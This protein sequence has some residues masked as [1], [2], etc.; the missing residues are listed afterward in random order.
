MCIIV[1]SSSF[2]SCLPQ[3]A[4]AVHSFG[5]KTHIEK[6]ASPIFNVFSDLRHFLPT[7]KPQSQ[8]TSFFK[9]LRF[10][11]TIYFHY[12]GYY[13]LKKCCS[14]R[15]QTESQKKTP[16]LIF[17]RVKV[18]SWLDTFRRVQEIQ[19]LKLSCFGST[20]M[21]HFGSTHASP[22]LIALWRDST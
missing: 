1:G 2:W 10:L 18:S 17:Q 19:K 13:D 9:S 21:T 6:S 7:T 22:P 11:I 8:P 12:N 15:K 14:P 3:R 5:R 16:N 20:H 4:R